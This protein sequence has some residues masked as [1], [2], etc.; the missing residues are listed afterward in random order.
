MNN[1]QK[2]KTKSLIKMMLFILGLIL[3]SE[4]LLAAEAGTE[5]FN[6][7]QYAEYVWLILL[8]FVLFLT[9]SFMFFQ[10]PQ[11]EVQALFHRIFV[12]FKDKMTDMKPIDEEEDILLDHEYDGIKE[13]DNNLPPWWKYLFYFSIVFAIFYMVHF[14][15]LGDGDVQANEYVQEMRNAELELAAYSN[16]N[17]SINAENVTLLE[18]DGS[19]YSGSEIFKTH[20]A[21]CHA[22]DGGGLVGPNLTDKYWIHGGGLSDIFITIQEGVPEKGMISWKSQLSPK[23]IQEVSSYVYLL[24]GTTPAAPKAPEGEIYTENTESESDSTDQA[25]NESTDSISTQ[26][27]GMQ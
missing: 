20:C 26:Q 12:G 6:V 23:D 10:R 19:L 8:F 25:N 21:A 15:V 22:K 1:H 5:S 9:A 2:M 4:T 16:S 7:T 17:Q 11:N 13:L 24:R 3:T 18:D 27:A 14:H